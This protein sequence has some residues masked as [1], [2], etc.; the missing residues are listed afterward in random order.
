MNTLPLPTR[1][2]FLRI[3]GLGTLGAAAMSLLN[4]CTPAAPQQPASQQAAGLV[5]PTAATPASAGT[6][7]RGGTLLAADEDNVTSLDPHKTSGFQNLIEFDHFYTA[8]ARY[9]SKGDIEPDLATSWDVSPDGLE[10]TF[11]LRPDVKFHNGRAL[12]SDDVKYSVER[13]LAKETAAPYRS[14]FDPVDKIETPDNTTVKFHLKF[15]YTPFLGGI[16]IKRSSAVVPQEV[17]EKQQDLS[18]VA[19][20]TG[21]WTLGDWVQNDRITMNRFTDYYE[22]GLP[23]IDAVNYKILPEEATRIAA[24]RAKQVDYAFLT[25]QGAQQLNGDAN[26]RVLKRS[27][28]F[29]RVGIINTQRKPLDD[30]RVRKALDMALDRQELIQ[31]GIGEADISGPIPA[32]HPSYALTPDDL[33]AYFKKPDPD[34]AK[35]L[36]AE[37]GLANGFS[38]T[39]DIE[40][41]KYIQ[42]LVETMQAQWKKIGVDAQIKVYPSGTL[43]KTADKAGG[44][45]FGVRFT[46]FTFYPDADNYVYNWYHSDSP[47]LASLAPPWNDPELDTMMEKARTMPD[48]PDRRAAYVAI[49]RRL[50]DTVPTFWL[51]N[52]LYYE[53]LGTP[54][55][56]FE[57]NPPARRG[58]SVRTTWLDRA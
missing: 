52:E 12:V 21:P 25:Y 7:K 42:P 31:K 37:A 40:P 9:N 19:V 33:P 20:G 2:G 24:L 11:H 48:G 14:Y 15:P 41:F 34:G 35:R 38:M 46:A 10:Y 56:G 8:L 50:L 17:V 30:V 27:N 58:L 47:G 29:V 44:Y 57:Q 23:Y 4:A 55:R 22:S 18:T 6:P 5:G 26:L 16:A 49:Q 45:N 1:R 43:S 53:G 36:L 32:G 51:H 13:V 39:L 3:L 54:V 28:G